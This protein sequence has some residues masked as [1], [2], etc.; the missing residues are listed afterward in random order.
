[1]AKGLQ[2]VKVLVNWGPFYEKKIGKS[3]TMPKKTE[4]DPLGFFNIHSV[5][6]YQKVEGGPFGQK[7]FFRKKVSRSRKY[8]KR[9]GPVE[10]FR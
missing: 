9:V 3:P 1:M 4:R 2:N 8:S 7:F 6:K 10:F 5:G